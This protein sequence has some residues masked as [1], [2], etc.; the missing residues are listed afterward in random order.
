MATRSAVSVIPI[1]IGRSAGRVASANPLFLARRH[2]IWSRKERRCPSFAVLAP[3]LPCYLQFCAALLISSF[4]LRQFA[5]EGRPRERGRNSTPARWET[6]LERQRRWHNRSM[7]RKFDR[8][9]LYFARPRLV[10]ACLF[11]EFRLK[12]LVARQ[13]C[14]M[15]SGACWRRC[16]LVFNY[17]LP[18][19]DV[20]RIVGTMLAA[21]GYR[22]RLNLLGPA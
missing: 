2:P 7:K 17:T 21:H 1:R 10:A 14:E 3:V 4:M 16:F 5:F 18:D 20:V 11:C 12:G 9:C 13:L 15:T 6:Y 8:R 19:R 22:A